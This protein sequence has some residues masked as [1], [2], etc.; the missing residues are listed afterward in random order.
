M[1]TTLDRPKRWR[2]WAC[3]IALQSTPIIFP[4]MPPV[5]SPAISGQTDTLT[6]D[7]VLAQA[8]TAHPDLNL[9]RAQEEAAQSEWALASSLNDFQLSLE[10]ALRS[11]RNAVYNDRFHPDH[12]IALIARKKLYDAGR[13]ETRSN[14]AREEVAARGLQIMETRAQRRLTL[15]ARYFDVLIAD[16]QYNADTEFTAVNYVGWDNAKDR[17]ALGQMT[18]GE[19]LELEARYLESRSRRNDAGRKLR[20]KRMQLASAMSRTSLVLEELIDPPLPGNNR[21]L[22]GLERL[23]TQAMAHNPKLRAQQ[24]WLAAARERVAAARSDYRPYLELE[25]SASAWSRDASTRDEARAGLNFVIPLWQGNRQTASVAREQARIAELEAQHS[26]LQ[27]ELRETLLNTWEEIQFLQDSERRNA[28]AWAAHKDM[29]L[30][31]AR[32]E[33]ELELKTNLGTSMAETQVARLKR[34]SV[35]YR[36]A[37]AW[38]RLEALLGTPLTEVKTKE[39]A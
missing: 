36:L 3:L 33:Y 5:I 13:S 15:M 11:G 12:Q 22:P 28:E 16:M 31:K 25:T 2:I 7:T 30:E 34:R 19:L 6:L 20:E 38:E 18:Q 24:Q 27:M 39:P 4:A 32:A 14:A 1:K 37:L 29:S 26:K 10:G 9:A 35:E 23:V 21:K 17:Q 8:D